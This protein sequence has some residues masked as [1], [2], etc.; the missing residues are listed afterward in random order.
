[1]ITVSTDLVFLSVMHH[2]VALLVLTHLILISIYPHFT[3]EKIEAQRCWVTTE[4]RS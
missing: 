4:T 1:M 2:S 3:D